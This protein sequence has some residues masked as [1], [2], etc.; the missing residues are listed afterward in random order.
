M[1]YD[2]LFEP[3]F[4]E[5][6][7]DKIG[8]IFVDPFSNSTRRKLLFTRLKAFL[9]ELKR[10][11]INFEIWIDGSFATKKPDPADVDL[12][13]LADP[14]E[15]NQLPKNKKSIIEKLLLGNLTAIKLRY[16]CDV[17]F[18]PNNDPLSEV[19]GEDGLVSLMMKTRKESHD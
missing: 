18:F 12:A 11:G 10:T 13:I 5:I 14:D 6:A 4:H 17:Y 3:G 8:E 19:T 7:F 2:P 16:K 1:D 15:I 9:K